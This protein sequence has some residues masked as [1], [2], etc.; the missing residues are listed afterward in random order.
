MHYGTPVRFFRQ[1]N[2]AGRLRGIRC[3]EPEAT[4]FGAKACQRVI[5]FLKRRGLGV[6]ETLRWRLGHRVRQGLW[7]VTTVS[8]PQ[9]S[10]ATAALASARFLL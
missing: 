3:S 9:A 5:D 4:L 6:G 10:P 2:A 8:D 7:F 1:K